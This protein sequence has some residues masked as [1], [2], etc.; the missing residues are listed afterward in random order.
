MTVSS[1]CN[2]RRFFHDSCAHLY[3]IHVYNQSEQGSYTAV[4]NAIMMRF[5]IRDN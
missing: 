1:E 4:T 2:G 3:W 5:G